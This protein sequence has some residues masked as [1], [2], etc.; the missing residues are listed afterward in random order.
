MAPDHE[1]AAFTY[2]LKFGLHT[3]WRRT[4]GTPE[5]ILRFPSA[6]RIHATPAATVRNMILIISVHQL[7]APTGGCLDFGIWPLHDFGQ[8]LNEIV[9]PRE[10]L[11]VE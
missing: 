6:A 7:R 1:Y 5:L 2:S 4:L 3:Y 8:L 10:R 9:E 11:A